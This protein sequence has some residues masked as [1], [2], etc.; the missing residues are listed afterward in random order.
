MAVV[1]AGLLGFGA[2]RGWNQEWALGAHV[3]MARNCDEGTFEPER[4]RWSTPGST[5]TV[6]LVGDS[7]AWAMADG[8]IPAAASLGLDTVVATHNACPFA[9]DAG[10]TDDGA[11]LS[12][13]CRTHNEQLLHLAL[14]LEPRVVVIA[15]Q[16]AA[17]ANADDISWRRA[18]SAAVRPLR[19]A[20]VGVMLVSVAPIG[21]EESARTTLLLRGAPDRYTLLSGQ[22]AERSQATSTD[23]VVAA[24]NPGT[25]VFDPA[26]TLCDEDGRCVV[27]RGGRI[28]YS[29][30]SHLSR[31]GA[32]LLEPALRASLA[33]AS[34]T[35]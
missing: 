30:R 5:G 26:H 18:L 12:P 21:D 10:G 15:N 16:S 17:Y 35:A 3:A 2:R 7:Q 25:V 27:A 20:G 31:S 32:L 13:A 24:D 23:R 33:R 28:Y 14:D 1:M 34:T 19:A 29:D 9:L 11:F 22:A 4:C 8:L 6:L